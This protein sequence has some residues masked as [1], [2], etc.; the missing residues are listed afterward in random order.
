MAEEVTAIANHTA[1]VSR[2]GVGCGSLVG[3]RVRVAGQTATIRWGPGHVQA[4]PS[5]RP[6][7]AKEVGPDTGAAEAGTS[8]VAGADN[9]ATV[10]EKPTVEVLGIEYDEPGHG[11]HDGMHQG[12]R[13]FQCELGFGSFIK[14]EKAELGIPF[15]RALAE[16]YFSAMLPCAAHRGARSEAVDAVE[17]VDS[18]GR[19]KEMTVEL[20]GRYGVEQRQQRL[21]GFVEMAVAESNLSCRYPDNVW[22]GDWSLPNLKSLWLDRTLIDDWSDVVAICEVCPQL[23]WLSV[24]RT[25]I[26]PLRLVDGGAVAPPRDLPERVGEMRLALTPFSCQVR[27][28]ILSSSAVTWRDL[29]ALDAAAVFPCLEHLHLAQNRLSEGIPDELATTAEAVD[30]AVASNSAPPPQWRQPFPSLKTLVLDK[31]GISDW[32]VIRRAIVTFPGLQA[33]HLNGNLLGETLDGLAELGADERPR[34][35]TSLCLNENLLASWKAIGALSRYALLDLKLQRNPVTDG[36]SPV[37]SPQLLRQVLIALMPTILRLNASE[38]PAKERVAAERYLL[39]AIGQAGNTGMP[40]ALGEACDMAAHATRLRAV[41]GE[42]VGGDVTEEG[43]AARSALVHALVEVSLRPI[44]AAILDQPPVK[45]RLPHTMTVAELKR[46]SQQIFK[47][48]P[49]PRVRL[50]LADPGLPFG[51]PFDDESRELGFYGVCDGAEIRV[52]DAAD[53]S[54]EREVSRVEGLAARMDQAV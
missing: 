21:E 41:H 51:V 10:V 39:A 49:L 8:E 25:R 54:G 15:Q 33:L 36:T 27:T 14:V 50:L 1:P 4:P 5:K 20:V 28:L 19:D 48:V 47:Q 30:A 16:K 3:R 9:A 46:L 45:K 37:A 35:L 17:F 29:L 6:P 42:V 12:E 18:K 53:G 40:A 2:P 13:L 7:A 34:C 32:R 43:Q 26:G 38:I 44:G 22:D 24:V 11:K 31:N 52:D 23:E